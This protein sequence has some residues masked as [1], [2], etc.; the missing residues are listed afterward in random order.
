MLCFPP[1]PANNQPNAIV[2]LTM[3]AM[4]R[5]TLAFKAT[6]T[7]A[8]SPRASFQ[9]ANFG[10]PCLKTALKKLTVSFQA[11]SSKPFYASFKNECFEPLFMNCA[12]QFQSSRFTSPLKPTSKPSIS[13]IVAISA[14]CAVA[15]FRGEAMTT[16][17]TKLFSFILANV[18]DPAPPLEPAYRMQCHSC[19]SPYLEEHFTYISHLYR[20]PLAF[21]EKC[22]FDNFDGKYM[23]TKNCTDLCV[24]LKMYDKVGGRRRYGYMR[25]CMSDIIH[26]N[27]S[28]LRDDRACYDVRLQNLFVTSNVYAF[29]PHDKVTIC[30]CHKPYCNS[31]PSATSLPMALIAI[32]AFFAVI[33]PKLPD[34]NPLPG[35]NFTLL[36]PYD[37]PM[38]E[39]NPRIT[40]ASQRTP[41]FNTQHR[42]RRIPRRNVQ[43]AAIS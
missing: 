13:S 8:P 39:I 21:T 20:K 4:S 16:Q 1:P 42:R 31:A 2:V 6:H 9:F 24:S 7:T 29:E 17:F 30:P 40:E 14:K 33:L 32:S 3:C 19:M 28:V 18:H 38:N 43:E 37:P 5:H 25:G 36:P 12:F 34:F 15:P 22:D 26:Y 35:S 27:R 23:R 41:D 10:T 11:W